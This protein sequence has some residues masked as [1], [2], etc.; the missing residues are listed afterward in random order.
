MPKYS[1]LALLPLLAACT[2]PANVERVREFAARQDP[3]TFTCCEKPEKSYPKPLV[4]AA[5]AFTVQFADEMF[6][7]RDMIYGSSGDG[8]AKVP[9]KL[10]DKPG[11]YEAVTSRLRPM[12]LALLANKSHIGGN[13]VPGRFTH[14]LVYLG[15]EA[16]LRAA[17]LWNLPELVPL[18][19]RIRN[20]EHFLE[21]LYP[22]V[23]LSPPSDVLRTDGVF[24][25]HPDLTLAQ[26]RRGLTAMLARMGD[27]F[28]YSFDNASDDAVSC[29]ELVGKALPEL[30]FTERTAFGRKVFFPDDVA[31]QTIR[32]GEGLHFLGYVHGTDTG[33][34]VRGIRS[35]MADITAYWGGQF[36]REA[37]EATAIGK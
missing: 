24:L 18:H 1:A 7:L 28:D 14:M 8:T 3:A 10:A 4:D 36:E 30:G 15:S 29:T 20:G 23:D 26:K 2:A 31:A 5:L 22:V 21:A 6:A 34:E 11:A 25:I 17:G 32:G 12:D 37:R 35:A 27:P 33:Y 13:I 16:E 19:P 9:G